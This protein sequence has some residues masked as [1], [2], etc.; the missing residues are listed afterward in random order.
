MHG[1]RTMFGHCVLRLRAARSAVFSSHA[2][3]LYDGNFG[4]SDPAGARLAARPPSSTS[5]SM[6]DD[7]TTVN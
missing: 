6:G 2:P 5:R 4:I 1:N 7:S 3:H